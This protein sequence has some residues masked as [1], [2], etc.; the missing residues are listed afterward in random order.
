[1]EGIQQLIC[2]LSSGIER[3]GCTSVHVSIDPPSVCWG[4]GHL[5]SS[6]RSNCPWFKFADFSHLACC[7]RHCM[8]QL[9]APLPPVFQ[10]LC[11]PSGVP[12]LAITD[13]QGM[14]RDEK[15]SKCSRIWPLQ[16][17]MELSK[18]HK[19]G[20]TWKGRGRDAG[21]GH[22]FQVYLQPH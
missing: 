20:Q 10:G 12:S 9:S 8:S 19:T 14:K 13:F 17:I 11:S 21:A 16:K 4:K 22:S 2:T 7:R 6:C 18:D 5:P 1:M 3:E 15:E